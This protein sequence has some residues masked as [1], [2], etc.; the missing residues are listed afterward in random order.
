MNPWVLAALMFTF[1][2]VASASAAAGCR[3]EVLKTQPNNAIVI[4]SYHPGIQEAPK[5]YLDCAREFTANNERVTLY[6]THPVDEQAL[7]DAY[8]EGKISDSQ[9]LQST[10]WQ[11]LSG[12]SSIA[13]F[14][15]LREIRDVD[16]PA[17]SVT[18]IGRQLQPHSMSQNFFLS[19][20]KRG[21]SLVLI[22]SREALR[23]GHPIT[24]ETFAA[25]VHKRYP[26][27]ISLGARY[28]G[29]TVWICGCKDFGCYEENLE[30]SQQSIPLGLTMDAEDPRLDGYVNFG[31]VHATHP[32]KPLPPDYPTFPKITCSH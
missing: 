28:E 2:G 12:R 18:L 27:S 22:D 13:I 26:K 15:M 25:R 23:S 9:L 4:F 3:K 7:Y 11:G 29:G 20:P 5:Y 31:T 21:I 14:Q 10:H 16:F 24:G 6:L 8:F 17:I 1:C 32:I 30:S 19:R